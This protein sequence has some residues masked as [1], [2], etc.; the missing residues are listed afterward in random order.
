MAKLQILIADD[1]AVLRE[2]LALLIAGE[3]DME[4]VGQASDG[5]D[6]VAKAQELRPDVL[7]I[8]IT[9]PNCGGIQALRKIGKECPEIRS[10]VLTMHDDQT[11]LRSVL[12]A[13]GH[14]YVTKKTVSKELLN[15]IR[16]VASGR[17]YINVSLA[18]GQMTTE[19]HK[20][21]QAKCRT[22]DELSDR[23]RQVLVSVARGY[24]SKEIATELGISSAS[25][26][27]YRLRVSR[28]LS[29]KSRADL[30]DY[31]LQ[32]G[33]LRARSHEP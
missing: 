31:A 6:A 7:I 5:K 29:A 14:G 24:T 20:E 33:L 11:F 13:G 16:I 28:K 10:L 8:D 17:Q 15:A 19:K 21:G 25:V 32:A 30:V 4:V 27:S 18:K 26:D 9:M 12:R 2:T 22:L 23:E 3:K 1:H